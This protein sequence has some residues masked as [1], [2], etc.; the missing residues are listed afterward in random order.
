MTYEIKRPRN[1]ETKEHPL[2]KICSLFEDSEISIDTV[3]LENDRLHEHRKTT[4][5]YFVIAGEGKIKID[6][7]TETLEPD[8]C[9]IIY[10][11]T[12][13]RAKATSSSL[14]LLVICHPPHT[15]EDVFYSD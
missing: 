7:K 1:M 14:K 13:H 3:E 2:A 15:E 11:G 12:R 10:P 8:T 6:N 4:E 5:I 9:V